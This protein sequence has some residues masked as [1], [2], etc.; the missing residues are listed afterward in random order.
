[1]NPVL[2]FFTENITAKLLSVAVAA[3]LWVA[4]VDEPELI[5]TVSVPV[6]YRNLSAELD[7]SPDAPSRVQI[8]VRG[9]RTRLGEVNGERTNVVLDLAGMRQASTRT[10]SIT[11]ETINLPSRVSLVRAMPSQ[12]RVT[13]ERRV[14]REISVMPQFLSS[15]KWKV[16]AA[17]VSPTA[18]KIVGPE[19]SFRDLRTLNTEPIDLDKLD[20]EK[21]ISVNVLLPDPELAFRAQPTVNVK[22]SVE[23]TTAEATD[24]P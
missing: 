7:L 4:L 23:S 24:N 20:P 19:S 2:R 13:L 9:P 16:L 11:P 15:A 8:Q 6:E 14:E 21:P 17:E 5:E 10:F 1:M 18:V 22:V 12:M 3:L